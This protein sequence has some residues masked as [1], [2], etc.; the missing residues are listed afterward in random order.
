MMKLTK[1]LNEMGQFL[2]EA[3]GRIFMPTDQDYPEI[4]VQPFTGDLHRKAVKAD[5]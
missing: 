5:Y 4:G 3:I 2:T 1:M